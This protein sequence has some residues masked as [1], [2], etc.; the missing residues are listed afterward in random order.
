MCGISGVMHKNRSRLVDSHSLA[1]ANRTLFHRGPDEGGQHVDGNVGLAHRRLSIIDVSDGHQPMTNEDETIWLVFNGEIYNYKKLREELLRQGHEFRSRSDSEVLVHLYEEKGTS[2]VNYLDG[3]FAFAIWDRKRR[4]LFIARDRLGKKPLYYL[5]SPE[6]FAFASEIKA[7]E[8]LVG[9][10]QTN[11]Q[12]SIAEYF[13]YGYVGGERTLFD[14]VKR[15]LPGHVMVVDESGLSTFCYWDVTQAPVQRTRKPVEDVIA[16]FDELLNDAVE[17]RLMSEVPLGSFNSGGLDSSLVTAIAAKKL[18]RSINTFSVSFAE[19]CFDESQYAKLVSRI[20]N[21]DHHILQVNRYNFSQALES[22]IW[23]LDEPLHYAN[24]VAIL[25]LSKFAKNDVTVVLTGEG[26]D[27]VLGGYP[28][29]FLAKIRQ[30]AS[31]LP[32]GLRRTLGKVLA[33][34]KAEKVRKIGEAIQASARDAVVLNEIEPAQ[35]DIRRLLGE[36]I[37]RAAVDRRIASLHYADHEIVHRLLG[38]EL[39]HYLAS[40]LNR[41]DK[42]TMAGGIEAR[43]PFLDYRLVEYCWTLPIDLRLHNWTTKF[44]LKKYGPKYLPTEIVI[45]RKS[46]FGIPLQEWFRDRATLGYHLAHMY[47]QGFISG[48]AIK[49]E[50][51]HRVLGRHLD[52]KYE[53]E[54]VLWRLLNWHLWCRQVGAAGKAEYVRVSADASA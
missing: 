30:Y 18:G 48:D 17:K 38:H 26:A 1:E 25:L 19:E 53:H 23:H 32:D 11:D 15:L 9:A 33:N 51:V 52:G 5:D 20:Y 44:L 36:D 34:Q 49:P 14:G 2:M 43:V 3:M 27:E 40:I 24:S 35:R 29:Y 47:E 12:I 22:A 39:K 46:G 4:R 41:T 21:T 37:Y 10:R 45:R 28:R 13:I 8:P 6:T 50:E 54:V 7:L 42:M 31:I 16:D